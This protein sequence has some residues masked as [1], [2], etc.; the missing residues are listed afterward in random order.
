MCANGSA[1]R[2]YF[3]EQT[4]L[5]GKGAELRWAAIAGTRAGHPT[6]PHNSAPEAQGI[7]QGQPGAGWCALTAQRVHNDLRRNEGPAATA[8]QFAPDATRA[9]SSCGPARYAYDDIPLSVVLHTHT[10]QPCNKPSIVVVCEVAAI[11]NKLALV[12]L[13]DS[14]LGGA[15]TC[16]HTCP[17]AA[18][19]RARHASPP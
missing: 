10:P 6:S 14:W 4:S 8:C 12:W 13:E 5:G 3:L 18:P 19:L 15:T 2:F 1:R 7:T 9:H 17:H 16:C 11:Q